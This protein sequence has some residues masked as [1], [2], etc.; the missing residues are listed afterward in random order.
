[1]PLSALPVLTKTF[2]VSAEV[3]LGQEPEPAKRGPTPK[4]KPQ[5]ERLSHLPRTQQRFVIQMLD[6][7]LKQA[8]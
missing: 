6:T 5:L 8:S 4:L 2:G 3:L 7:V 1:M